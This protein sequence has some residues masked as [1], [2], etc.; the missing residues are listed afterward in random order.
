[1]LIKKRTEVLPEITVKPKIDR[2]NF[3]LPEIPR[4]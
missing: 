3:S 2:V 4:G 1:M